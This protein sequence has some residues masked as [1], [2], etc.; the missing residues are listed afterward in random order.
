MASSRDQQHLGKAAEEAKFSSNNSTDE[1]TTVS[2]DLDENYEFF[3]AGSEVEATDGEVKKVVL[4][5]DYHVVPLLF[6]IYFLQYLDKN[7]INFA[8]AYGLQQGT[9]LQG[10]D[11]SWLGSIFYFGYLAGQ[12]PSGYLLQRLPVGRVVSAT[13]IIWGAIVLTVS[14]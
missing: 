1:I 11:F 4:K 10:Q 12:I 5:I 14:K 3:K 7:A 6:V 8:N 13:V 9:H 2:Q